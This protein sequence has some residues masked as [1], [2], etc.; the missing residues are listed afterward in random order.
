[1]LELPVV[2]LPEDVVAVVPEVP[3]VPEDVDEEVFVVEVEIERVFPGLKES[4]QLQ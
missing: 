3:E 1:V 2:E 4:S